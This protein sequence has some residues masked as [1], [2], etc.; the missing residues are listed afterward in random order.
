MITNEINKT[1]WLYLDP[2]FSRREVTRVERS[3]NLSSISLL[4]T[5]TLEK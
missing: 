2:A 3:R 1:V 4:R 5:N